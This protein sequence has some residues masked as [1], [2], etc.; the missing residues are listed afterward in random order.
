MPQEQASHE[1]YKARFI[2]RIDQSGNCW[3]WTGGGANGYGQMHMDGRTHSAHRLSLFFFKGIG[4]KA[5][6]D[7][8]H[9]CDNRSCVN[10]NHLSY[11]TR[12]QNMLDA[13]YKGRLGRQIVS[14]RRQH[15]ICEACSLGLSDKLVAEIFGTSPSRIWHIKRAVPERLRYLAGAEAR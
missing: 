5:G 7:V 1:E 10:P 15:Q 4:I 12:R 9:S 8:M 13:S 14:V 3:Q 2:S 6:S 11:G